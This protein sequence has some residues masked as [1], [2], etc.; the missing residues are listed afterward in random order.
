[1]ILFLI[2][3]FIAGFFIGANLGKTKAEAE[4]IRYLEQNELLENEEFGLLKYSH[5]DFAAYYF[6]VYLPFNDFRRSYLSF[7]QQLQRSL[8]ETNQADITAQIRDKTIQVRRELER[9]RPPAQSP[10]LKESYEAYLESIRQYEQ[11]LRRLYTQNNLSAQQ[12]LQYINSFEEFA[13]GQAHWL[14]GQVLFYES[15]MLWE[16][17]YVT[18][19]VP[20]FIQNPLNVTFNQWRDLRFHQKTD[21]V[22]KLLQE[23]RI[24][25]FFNPEDA[26]VYLDTL[27]Q[28]S[29]ANQLNRIGDSF[30][31]LV[32]SGSIRQGDFLQNKQNYREVQFPLIPLYVE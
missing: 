27:A 23:Y 26:V 9:V 10:L 5:S 14:K 7:Y 6:N 18:K 12:V 31:V 13:N 20:E 4:F 28:S 1:M 22:A 21:L 25:G 24:Q 3:S 32:A 8:G 11:G 30:E 15:V 29:T 16:S 2:A 19:E 17:L